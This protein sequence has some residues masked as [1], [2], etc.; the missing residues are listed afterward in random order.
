MKKIYLILFALLGL[1]LLLLFNL[2]FT[3]WPE[4]LSYAYLKNSGFSLYGGMVHPYPP[5]LTL[6]LSYLYKIFGYG[7]PVERAFYYLMLLI[8]DVSVFLIA[9]KITGNKLAALASVSV[10]ILTQPGLIMR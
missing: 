7:I 2:Q 8:N 3:A 6:T 10:Y 9:K 1:H 4:I 5:L